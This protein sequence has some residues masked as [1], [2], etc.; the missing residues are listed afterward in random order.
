MS[1]FASREV[2][3]A[4]DML[5]THQNRFSQ[6]QLKPVSCLKEDY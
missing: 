2:V 1:I 3:V 5:M 4:L 6:K